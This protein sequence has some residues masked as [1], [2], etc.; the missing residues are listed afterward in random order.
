MTEKITFFFFK[1]TYFFAGQERKLIIVSKAKY[2]MSTKVQKNNN[3][4]LKNY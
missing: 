1:V 2:G 3:I 4:K